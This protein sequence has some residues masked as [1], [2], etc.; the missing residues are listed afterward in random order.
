[1]STETKEPLRIGLDLDNTIVCYDETFHSLALARGLV[2]AGLQKSKEAVRSHLIGLDREDLWTELQGEAYGPAMKEAQPFVGFIDFL[3]E[4]L[5][6]QVDLFIVSHRS[7]RPYGSQD[8]D[9]HRAAGE[10]IDGKLPHFA[11]RQ[12]RVFLEETRANKL[13]RIKS[14]QLHYFIDDMLALLRDEAFPANCQGIHFA[15]HHS[16][17]QGVSIRSLATWSEVADDILGALR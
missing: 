17:A 16:A 4:A 14:L 6:Q 15:P 7:L 8:Y 10:W 3:S 1:M 12:D 5:M 2:P 9:L 11:D 13:K